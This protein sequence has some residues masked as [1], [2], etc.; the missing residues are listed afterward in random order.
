MDVDLSSSN[1][2]ESPAAN[3]LLVESPLATGERFQTPPSG[4]PEANV[5]P[6]DVIRCRGCQLVQFRTISDRCRRCSKSLPPKL[7]LVPRNASAG[8]SPEALP[9]QSPI[10]T[11]SLAVPFLL[12]HRHFEKLKMGRLLQRFRGERGMTQGE[13]ALLAVVPRSYVS[14]IENDHLLPGPRIASR[15]AAVLAVEIRD[16]LPG[17]PE[18]ARNGSLSK[19]PTCA[20]L[21]AGFSRLQ[22]QEMAAVL[23]EV[24]HMLAGN[25]VTMTRPESEGSSRSKKRVAIG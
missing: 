15:L 2:F 11:P 3:G 20:Q 6:R 13:L 10:R 19:D 24:R 5:P 25:V 22:P 4:P 7:M 21:C 8:E 16:L 1:V 9:G 17:A 14:R 12:S 18:F 23:S